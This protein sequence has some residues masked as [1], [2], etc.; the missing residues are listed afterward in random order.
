[1][2]FVLPL[3]LAASLF[4][5]ASEDSK[6]EVPKSNLFLGNML[7]ES[8]GDT[9]VDSLVK[10]KNLDGTHLALQH[11][12]KLFV[13]DN[14]HEF[15]SVL[16]SPKSKFLDDII[17]LESAS[18]NGLFR[19]TGIVDYKPNKNWGYTL[20]L[21]GFPRVS[22]LFGEQGQLVLRAGII[23]DSIALFGGFFGTTYSDSNLTLD[24]D[25]WN[26]GNR[27]DAHGFVAA[28]V[29]D[30]YF[31]F[32]SQGLD[33]DTLIGIFSYINQRGFAF[34]SQTLVDLDDKLQFGKLILMNS[35][36]YG[37]EFLDFRTRVLNNT[38]MRDVATGHILDAWPPY[39]QVSTNRFA[40]AFDWRNNPNVSLL[41]SRFVYRPLNGLFFSLGPGFEYEKKSGLFLPKVVG[42]IY[43]SIPET[44]LETSIHLKRDLSDG[45]FEFKAYVGLV[46]GF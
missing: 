37:K 22:V 11:R 46:N 1:M 13:D 6:V 10:Y 20:M 18:N 5:E 27:F 19:A 29:N 12:T 26:D 2:S 38:E 40:L 17:G 16:R 14:T 7:I 45:D 4:G 34:H 41:D 9:N 23:Q 3:A 30:F 25:V 39:D 32:G 8:N 24:F 33:R 35:S 21:E 15:S 42:D 43:V 28:V 44:P 31:S 36:N